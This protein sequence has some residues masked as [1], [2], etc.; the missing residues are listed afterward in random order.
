MQYIPP[1]ISW[2]PREVFSQ[3]REHVPHLFLHTCFPPREKQSVRQGL[4]DET[5]LALPH[6]V[7]DLRFDEGMTEKHTH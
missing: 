4:K 2:Q 1:R 5:N 7:F 3:G 6:L